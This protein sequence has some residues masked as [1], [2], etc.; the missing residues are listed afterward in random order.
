[1]E[2]AGTHVSQMKVGAIINTSSGGCD[3]ESEIEML[4]IFKGAGVT[5]C[6]T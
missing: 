5:N 4:D 6:K 1:M 2:P 3:P